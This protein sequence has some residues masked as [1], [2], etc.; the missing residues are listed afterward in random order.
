MASADKSGPAARPNA[1][2][3]SRRKLAVVLV[4][5]VGVAVTIAVTIALLLHKGEHGMVA[6]GSPAPELAATAVRGG[7]VSIA[8]LR[9]HVLLLSFVDLR[10]DANTNAPSRA[11]IV[12]LSSM[13]KQHARYGVRLILVDT[14]TENRDELINDTYDWNLDPAIAVVG[15]HDV[16]ARRFGVHRAPTTFLIGRRGVV[17]KRWDGFVAAA[18]LDFA[19]RAAEGRRPTG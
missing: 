17:R 8:R 1:M 9:G 11:E 16:F 6:I 15:D 14:A 19:I 2:R 7:D 4:A 10:A 18:Q 5:A 12:F 13:Q 3:L